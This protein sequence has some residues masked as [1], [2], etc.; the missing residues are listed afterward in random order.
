MVFELVEEDRVLRALELLQELVVRL[1]HVPV[2]VAL[3]DVRR[4][5]RGL[6]GIGQ[7]VRLDLRKPRRKL[8]GR[9]ERLAG[10]RGLGLLAEVVLL[11]G[12]LAAAA[13]CYYEHE[14]PEDEHQRT[15]AEHLPAF[16]E[17]EGPRNAGLYRRRYE[18]IR[19]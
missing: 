12:L 18:A 9:R 13:A 1:L 3:D 15:F 19:M 10:A 4:S 14:Q 7:L 8:G 2:E 16:R 17:L 11:G 5:H 6:L